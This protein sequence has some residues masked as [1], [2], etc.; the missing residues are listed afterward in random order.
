MRLRHKLII[1]VLIVLLPLATL[2]IIKIREEYHHSIERELTACEELAATVN[3]TYLNYLERIWISE[4]AMGLYF[5]SEP[6]LT[7]Q[8]IETYILKIQTGQPSILSYSWLDAKGNVLASTM[9]G[10]SNTNL[11]DL[12]HIQ[13]IQQGEDRVVAD[14]T[15]IKVTG[16]TIV[17]VATAIRDNE[18]KLLG[19]VTAG[20]NPSMLGDVLPTRH[21]DTSISYGLVDTQGRVVYRNDMKNIA[22]EMETLATASPAWGA[23]HGKITKSEIIRCQFNG[24]ERMGI[25]YPISEIGWSSFVTVDVE[26]VLAKYTYDR[27]RDTLILL[28]VAACSFLA[29][30]LLGYLCL[31]PITKIKKAAQAIS[32]G[33]FA[34]RAN[35]DG[36]DEIAAAANTFDFMAAHLET[37]LHSNEHKVQ[38]IFD[39]A[40]LGIMVETK[41]G[42]IIR[43]NPTLQTMLGYSEEELRGLSW[44][45]ITHPDDLERDVRLF[46]DLIGGILQYYQLKKRYLTKTNQIIWVNISVVASPS[47]QTDED[48]IIV[49]I[50]DIT[51]KRLMEEKILRL[52]EL[53]LIGEMAAGISH[54]IRNPMTSVRGFLQMLSL[55][56]DCAKY[57]E[58]FTLMI[59]ELDRANA[60]I[61]EFLSM[62]RS[63]ATA[64]RLQ[65]LNDVIKTLLPLLEADAASHDKIIETDLSPLIDL[66]LNEK[67]I[68]QLTLNLA[69]N[70]FEAM[71]KGGRLTIQTYMEDGSVVL[72]VHDQG[73]G[74]QPEI[75]AKL[76]TPFLTTKDNG[77]GLGLGICYSIAARHNAKISVKTSPNG[78]TFIV[79]FAGVN[80]II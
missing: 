65:N 59:E 21:I 55:K 38:M 58:Y 22:L 16:R 51:E 71:S 14:L 25:G 33:D 48:F 53:N 11:A 31:L 43:T 39:N 79:K 1:L 29:A 36:T 54:E 40:T 62:G 5:T 80:E 23:R 17:P 8:D 27:F 15:V 57:A 12:A 35:V 69:R 18:R 6:P 52:D 24:H 10:L 50:E 56:S 37:T 74:I 30:I 75:L 45:D 68:R 66:D 41:D 34:A 13:R 19:I 78:T 49:F 7:P 9:P 73:E 32:N 44:T 4:L 60:I 20:I 63:K 47:R 46:Q 42:K 77:T 72:A 28:I 64:M 26:E 61:T 76:G 67:E 2:N 70:G 3:S